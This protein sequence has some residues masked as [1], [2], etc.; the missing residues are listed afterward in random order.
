MRDLLP[1]RVGLLEA[2]VDRLIPAD[3]DPGAIASGALA[4]V[5][6]RLLAESEAVRADLRSGMQALDQSCEALCGRPFMLASPSEQDRAL[7]AHEREPWFVALSELAAEGFYADPGN[8][9]NHDAVSWRMIGYDP[10]L[11]LEA[12]PSGRIADAGAIEE[13]YDAIVVGAGAGGG[14]V[15]CLLA[16]AGHRVLVL[17]RGRDHGDENPLTRDHLRNQRLSVYDHNAGP[18][19]VGYPRVAVDAA[20]HARELRPHQPGYQ[21]N[22]AAVGG[23]TLVYGAQA[24]RFHPDDFSMASRYGA[25]AGSSMADW[26]FD[27][28]ALAPYYERAEREIGVAGEA[29][30]PAPRARPF[31]MPPAAGHA[32]RRML[33]TGAKALGLSTFAAPLL[34]NTVPR[35]G[36]AACVECGSCVGFPCP[37]D[38][39]NG[40]QNT[41]LARA[42]KTGR[43]AIVDLAAVTEVNVDDEGEVS[44]VTFVRDEG[45]AVTRRVVRARAVVL[46]GGAIETARLLL[47]SRS[48]RHPQG[49][50]NEHDLVGRNLQGH[51]SAIVHGLF[52]APVYDRRGPGV[53]VATCRYNHGNPGIIGGSMIADDFIMLP[54]IFWKRALPPDLQRWGEPAKAFMRE[55]YRRVIRL[56]APVQDIPT[57]DSRVTLDDSVRDRWGSPVARLS[58]VAHPESVRT[59]EFMRDRALEWLRASGAVRV[60]NDPV[61]PRLSAGQHQAGTCRMGRDPRQSVTDEYGRVW[62]HRRLFIADGSLHPTN[63]GFNPVLTIMAVAFRNGE[64][65]AQALRRA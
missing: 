6:E 24:W 56:F 63:G 60:W 55:N 61:L 9:G 29:G 34:I 15:A 39:K 51:F 44:G 17:E 58:G 3:Q 46:C 20:G 33:E 37:S 42:V 36:R 11:P 38:G 52:D 21:N 40:T 32:S 41:V 19:I 65:I 54:V 14:I 43:C 28:E 59:A 53:T 48:P 16:E 30:H 4:F 25:P 5:R 18:N 22:A 45:R 1:D 8:G 31:P 7:K 62:G 26:P 23:G 2:V 35:D 10:N 50:G 12:A 57:P 13:F 49:L 47:L 27:Y 64:H